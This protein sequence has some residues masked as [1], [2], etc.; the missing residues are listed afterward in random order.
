MDWSVAL[1]QVYV[2]GNRGTNENSNYRNCAAGS[3][4]C[5]RLEC[6]T[7]ALA[8]ASGTRTK[9]ARCAARSGYFGRLRYDRGDILV[10]VTEPHLF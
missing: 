3:E 1:P 4:W 2:Q 8:A 5:E 6:D 7:E 10:Q 9:G